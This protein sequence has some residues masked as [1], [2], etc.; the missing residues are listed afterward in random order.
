[1]HVLAIEGVTGREKAIAAAVSAA[2][3][4]V[5]GVAAALWSTATASS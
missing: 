4:K 1:M 3:K 5:G 2:L